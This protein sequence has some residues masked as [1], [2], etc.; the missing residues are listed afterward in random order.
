MSPWTPAE[1]GGVLGDVDG[2]A[3]DTLLG[4][5]ERGNFEGSNVLSLPKPEDRMLLRDGRFAE[6]RQRVYQARARRVWPARPGEREDDEPQHHQRKDRDRSERVSQR[7]VPH[8]AVLAREQRDV[9]VRHVL[10]RAG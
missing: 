5:S 9:E 6:L 3:L 1:R 7:D 8:D 4:A 10:L 2:N